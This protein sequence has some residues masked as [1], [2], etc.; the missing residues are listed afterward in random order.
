MSIIKKADV[1]KHLLTRASSKLL[2]FPPKSQPDATGY[3]GG[4]TRGAKVLTPSSSAP[5]DARVS[6]RVL[7]SDLPVVDDVDAQ[8]R[9]K[10]SIGRKAQG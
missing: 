5:L 10:A 1:K 6:P 3:S 2:L 4:E 8:L 9:I 7:K